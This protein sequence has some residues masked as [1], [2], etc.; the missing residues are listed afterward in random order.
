MERE[1]DLSVSGVAPS[2][3]LGH[4]ISPLCWIPS[5]SRFLCQLANARRRL[6]TDRFAPPSDS[7]P[8]R[9]QGLAATCDPHSQTWCGGTWL[10]IID[11]LDY[12]QGMGFDA[13]WISP[14]STNIDVY[15]PYNYAY[16]GYWVTNPT[17]L[18]PRF[19]TS[20]DLHK[21]SNELHSRGMYLMVDV[22]VNN[23]PS[24]SIN[25]S[26]NAQA[27]KGSGVYWQD[28]EQYHDFCWVDYSNLTSEQY[29]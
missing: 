27:L 26:T 3:S 15:T 17:T 25:D 20:D 16:H 24:L 23:I 28:P 8:A 7:A 29:W 22:V 5:G 18:N 19:G 13:I 1:S 9:T 14:V 2:L 12:I 10:S 6:I 21:L 11:K 4:H